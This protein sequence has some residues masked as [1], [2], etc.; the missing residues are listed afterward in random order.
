MSRYKASDFLEPIESGNRSIHA[1]AQDVGCAWGTAKQWIANV[2]LLASAYEEARNMTGETFG[3]LTVLKRIGPNQHGQIQYFCRCKC[4]AEKV[5]LGSQLRRGDVVSCGC[6][7]LTGGTGTHKLSSVR[8]KRNRR[9][10]P[11]YK[12]WR[13]LVLQRYDYTCLACGCRSE[14][15]GSMCAHHLDNYSEYPE[16]ARSISNGAVLCADCHRRF[17]SLCGNDCV[18]EDFLRFLMGESGGSA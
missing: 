1:V 7:G 18:A 17:H 14:K 3:W 5:A 10:E 12:Q 9:K 13:R 6:F 2:P 16:K 15:R 11:G 4:G 8:W